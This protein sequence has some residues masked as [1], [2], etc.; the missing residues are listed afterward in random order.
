VA[1]KRPQWFSMIPADVSTDGFFHQPAQGIQNGG[2]RIPSGYHLK[3]PFLAGE[4]CLGPFSVLDVE[5]NR[6][7][8]IDPSLIVEQRIAADQEPAIFAVLVLRAKLLRISSWP[9]PLASVVIASISK[10]GT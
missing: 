9:I 10:G 3:E 5:R 8:S 1:H 7:P 6:I 2:K 4:Q